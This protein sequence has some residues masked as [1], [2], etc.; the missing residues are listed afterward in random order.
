L[1]RMLVSTGRPA[2]ALRL[3]Q[4]IHDWFSEG[5]DWPE[6]KDATS[7]LA[8]LKSTSTSA[9]GPNRPVGSLTH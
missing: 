8:D 9:T 7:I 4:P 2:E 3:L 6:F 5:F 1:S